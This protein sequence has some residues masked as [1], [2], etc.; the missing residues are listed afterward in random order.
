VVAKVWP[1]T[2]AS[3]VKLRHI[4]NLGCCMPHDECCHGYGPH[5]KGPCSCTD[6]CVLQC[7]ASLQSPH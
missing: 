5:D 7:C 1:A 4:G 3:T 6:F 2:L